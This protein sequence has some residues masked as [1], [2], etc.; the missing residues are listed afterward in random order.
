MIPSQVHSLVK[1]YTQTSP[2]AGAR[3]G[4]LHQQGTFA[5]RLWPGRPYLLSHVRGLVT[6]TRN[7]AWEIRDK[8]L[9]GRRAVHTHSTGDSSKDALPVTVWRTT[10]GHS[11]PG[12][13]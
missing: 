7:Q 1:D 3:A 11:I 10:T 6:G 12:T 13:L 8:D 5:S 2:P 4:V 9:G